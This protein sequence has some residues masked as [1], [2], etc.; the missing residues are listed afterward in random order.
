MRKTHHK[1]RNNFSNLPMDYILKILSCNYDFIYD[2]HYILCN[3]FDACELSSGMRLL[4]QFSII[5]VPATYS[6]AEHFA[7]V[8]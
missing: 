1:L 2:D 8:K 5:F 3:Y 7:A 6:E 4:C